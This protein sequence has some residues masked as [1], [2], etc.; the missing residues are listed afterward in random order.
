VAYKRFVDNVP[1]AIDRTMVRGL[2]VGLESALFNGMEISGAGGHERCRLLLS[3]P[4]GIV[5]RRTEL[6]KR[7]DRLWRAK[8]EL[9][10][11]FG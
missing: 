10:Q 1:M 11:A 8:E 7:R 4:E 3:E 5:A 2:K 6:Q 9:L